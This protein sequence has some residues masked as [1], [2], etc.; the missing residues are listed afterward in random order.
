MSAFVFNSIPA[1]NENPPYTPPTLPFNK[2]ISQVMFFPNQEPGYMFARIR[3]SS[4]YLMNTSGNI[5]YLVVLWTVFYLIRVKYKKIKQMKGKIFVNRTWWRYFYELSF[6]YMLK[7]HETIVLNF[8]LSFFLQMYKPDFH[9]V[10]NS[11]SFVCMVLC[12]GYY[13]KFKQVIYGRINKRYLWRNIPYKLKKYGSMIDDVNF[14]Q[15]QLNYFKL[16]DKSM[17]D[18]YIDESSSLKRKLQKNYHFIGF[19]KKLLICMVVVCL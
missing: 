11:I 17:Q 15:N 9:T 10:F 14:D 2:K 6:N 18:T 1:W 7:I 4:S 8:W 12:S 16:T 3:Y 19:I 5:F 13:L